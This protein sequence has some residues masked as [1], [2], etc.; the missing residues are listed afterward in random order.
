MPASALAAIPPLQM[1][2]FRED[3]ITFFAKVIIFFIEFI[4]VGH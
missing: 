3:N 2:F 1:I 4:C